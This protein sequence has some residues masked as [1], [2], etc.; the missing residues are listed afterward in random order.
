[1]VYPQGSK[2]FICSYYLEYGVR[3]FY[4]FPK[5]SYILFAQFHIRSNILSTLRT[6]CD[7]SGK[8]KSSLE[9]HTID[10]FCV[11]SCHPTIKLCLICFKLHPIISKIVFTALRVA[12]TS[13]GPIS[14]SFSNPAIV[15]RESITPWGRPLSLSSV[16]K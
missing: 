3:S 7:H 4:L 16:M 5:V 9:C 6:L 1:M 2:C 8:A 14:F 11:A 15:L 13:F 10:T 12:L